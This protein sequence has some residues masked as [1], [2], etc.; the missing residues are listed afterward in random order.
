MYDARERVGVS[1][2]LAFRSNRAAVRTAVLRA[3]HTMAD[4]LVM[5]KGDEL[6][7]EG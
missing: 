2:G 1:D 6:S 5:I 7:F 4:K 3:R